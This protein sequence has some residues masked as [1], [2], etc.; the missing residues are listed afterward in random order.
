MVYFKSL[1]LHS[2]PRLLKLQQNLWNLNQIKD[3]ISCIS[4][5]IPKFLPQYHQTMMTHIYIQFQEI[6]FET[7][8]YILKCNILVF[9]VRNCA[10]LACQSDII[11]GERGRGKGRDLLG[12]ICN[13]EPSIQAPSNFS[14]NPLQTPPHSSHNSTSNSTPLQSQSSPTSPHTSHNLLQNPPHSSHN[15]MSL[16]SQFTSL[17]TCHNLLQNPPHSSHNAMSLQSQFTSNSTPHSS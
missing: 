7:H 13:S 10:I 9:D 8:N 5:V 4:E 16:Q 2:L 15:A 12:L 6:L 3:S 14:H 1:K 11:F 17:H